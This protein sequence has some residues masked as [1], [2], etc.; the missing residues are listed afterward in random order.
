VQNLAKDLSSVRAVQAAVGIR[1]SDGEVGRVDLDGC[2]LQ[3][4]TGSCMLHVRSDMD[5]LTLA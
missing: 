5:L 1:K 4:M 3:T 2:L